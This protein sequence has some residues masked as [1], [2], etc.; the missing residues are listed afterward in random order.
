MQKILKAMAIAVVC[1]VSVAAQWP[2]HEEA[3]VPRDAQGRP[4]LDAPPPR[5]ADGKPDLSGI[6]RRTDRDPVPA[7]LAGLFDG[8]NQAAGRGGRGAAPPAPAGRRNSPSRSQLAA[9]CGVLGHRDQ[10]QGRSAADALGGGDQEAAHGHEQR[11]QSGR[12]L[13]AAGHSPAPHAPGPAADHPDAQAGRHRMGVQLRPA[14]HPHG[15]TEAAAARRAATVVVRLLRG[16][17]GRRHARRGNEQRQG[18]R[19]GAPSTGGWT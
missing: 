5:T 8:G 19:D 2:K 14:I 3:G 7:E 12:E 15:W 11:Q 16:A 6:W 18:R 17:L 4:R 10:H 1:S 13:P 9:R